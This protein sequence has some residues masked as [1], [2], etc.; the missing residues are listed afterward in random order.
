M[1]AKGVKDDSAADTED[2]DRAQRENLG[3]FRAEVQEICE[4]STQS[5]NDSEDVQP[6]RRVDVSSTAPSAKLQQHSRQPDCG[7]DNHCERAEEGRAVGIDHDQRQRA[8][9]QTGA[10]YSPTA[11]KWRRVCHVRLYGSKILLVFAVSANIARE[12]N[13]AGSGLRCW[14]HTWPIDFRVEKL[15]DDLEEFGGFDLG[16]DQPLVG[17][18]QGFIR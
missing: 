15:I 8:T 2:S 9:Q 13:D 6:G 3:Q 17:F 10:D 14:R 1:F 7:D 18:A 12:Q 16:F 11:R 5:K 4:S